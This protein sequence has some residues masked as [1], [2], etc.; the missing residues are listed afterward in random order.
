MNIEKQILDFLKS[1]P[2]SSSNQILKILKKRK[3][4]LQ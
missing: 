4:E 1:N 3:V 2:E